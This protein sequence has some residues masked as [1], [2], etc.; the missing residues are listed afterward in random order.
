MFGMGGTAAPQRV[1]TAH[2][3]ELVRQAIRPRL[4]V[5]GVV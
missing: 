2:I 3:E 1:I 4:S 5:V